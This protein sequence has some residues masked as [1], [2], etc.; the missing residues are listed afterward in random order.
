MNSCTYSFSKYLF[1]TLEFFLFSI[2]LKVYADDNV[3]AEKRYLSSEQ[4]TIASSAVSLDRFANKSDEWYRSQE[5]AEIIDNVLSWQDSEG[6]WPKNLSTTEKPFSGDRKEIHGTFDNGATTPE[7]KFLALAYRATKDGRCLDAVNKGLDVIFKAQYSTGGW[8]QSYPPDRQ[9]HRHITFNDGAIVRILRLLHDVSTSSVFDFIDKDR[10]S[11]AQKSFDRGIQCILNCQIIVNGK[12]TVWCAQHDE[13]DYRPRSGRA[14][15]LASLSGSESAGILDLL[16]SLKNPKPEVIRAV[17]AGAEWFETVKLSGIRQTKE[18]GNKIIVRDNNAMPLWA[19]FYEI[20]TNR[21][22]FSGRDGIKKYDIVEIDAERRNAYSWYGEWGSSVANNY[23]K[24]KEKWFDNSSTTDS[25]RIRMAI[26][27]ADAV[28]AADSS[29]QFKTVQDAVNAAP[30]GSSKPFRIYIKP[31]VYRELV[32]VPQQK[33]FLHLIGEDPATT[34]LTYYLNAN[35]P[36]DDGKPIGT[37]KTA[38][39]SIL[40]D[41]FQSDNIAFENSAGVGSQALAVRIDGDRGIF[42]NCRFLGWQDT[43][44]LN[45]GRHY[46]EACYIAGHVDFIFGAGTA[47]FEK[48]QIHCR[49]KGYITAASTPEDQAFGFVFS[50]CTITGEAESRRSFMGRPWRPYASVTFLNT[51]IA[52]TIEPAGWDNWR[53]PAREKTA[54]YAEYNSTGLGSDT[55]SRVKWAKQLSNMEAKTFS[56][57]NVLRGKDNWNPQ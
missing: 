18:N 15:E 51:N 55:R 38:T 20:E 43:M 7:I 13:I 14:Y 52:N 56:F 53:D 48:C 22:I 1:I 11:S 6:A 9:Y 30:D 10:R 2:G 26:E 24:W 37:F 16:M 50:N 57:E 27:K 45:A 49:A 41:D 28:V 5:G 34:V 21:P 25:N 31:G 33:R 47:F 17:K 36:G 8:P 4:G 12:L 39:V 46:F 19:R 42:H 29:G 3:K 35:M 40:G 54:R 32:V 44:L 23:S